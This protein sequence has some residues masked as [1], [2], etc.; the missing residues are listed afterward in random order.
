MLT[1]WIPLLALS[2]SALGACKSFAVNSQYSSG[3][4]FNDYK[5]FAFSPTA[6]HPPAG[7]T[8]GHLFNSIMQRRIQDEASRVLTSRGYRLVPPAEAS[9]Q[10]KISGGGSRAV[11]SASSGAPTS[12]G[13][14][15]GTSVVVERGALVLH[16]FDP[17][18]K[19]IIWRGWA[20]AVMSPDDDFDKKVRAGVR[21]ILSAY[22]PKGE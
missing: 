8:T 19:K 11:Q 3:E 18:K 10:I 22:P 13:A 17:E 7:Y 14:T 4:N 2:L 15:E 6:A 20:E 1:R 5:T 16:F 21:E 12:S 9:F